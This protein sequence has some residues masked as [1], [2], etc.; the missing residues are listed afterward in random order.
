MIDW[1]IERGW[2]SAA[3]RRESPNQDARPDTPID[4]LVVHGISLPPGQFGGAAIDDLFCN[5]LDAAAHPTFA[6]IA[7]LR[8][9]AHLLIRRD[10]A[11]CQFVAFDRRGW[12]AGKSSFQG[13]TR[14]NDYAIGIELEGTDHIPYEAV[15]YD[16]LARVAALLMRHYP[17]MTRDRIVGH[18]DIAP[19]RK[20]DPGPAF[21]WDLL[22]KK[23][24]VSP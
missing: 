21:D 1:H 3:Q 19:G 7:T 4:L 20:T 14:C 11:L 8:V 16:R 13:R 18:S 2:L 6:E 22:D 24:G 9:S 15:Q 12:H 10:G 17:A 23:L 5:R